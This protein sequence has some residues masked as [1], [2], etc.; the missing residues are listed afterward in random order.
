MNKEELYTTIKEVTT[1]IKCYKGFDSKLQCRGFQYEI[2][3]EYELPKGE[4]PMVCGNGFHACP[5]P[6]DLFL[7]YAPNNGN[8][9]CE[10]ELS[11]YI[12][13]NERNKLAASKIKIIRELPFNELAEAHRKYVEEHTDEEE[14]EYDTSNF[15][16]VSNTRT[17]SIASNMGIRSIACNSG[18]KSSVSNTGIFSIACNTGFQSSVTN[19]GFR[20]NSSNTGDFSCATNTGERSIA[21]NTG[22]FSSASNMGIRSIASN[23][24]NRSIASNMGDESIASNTGDYSCAE[25]SGKASFAAVF[26]IN[27]RVRGAI[28][29]GLFLTERGEWDGEKYPIKNVLAVIVDGEKVKANTWYKLVDGKLTEC[30]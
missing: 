24:G 5:N 23:T 27:C 20:S 3:K 29:C 26:G 4:M 14:K 11:G 1:P 9:F 21:S 22:D 13:D 12:D 2:G 16:T 7:F 8:R 28:G 17:Q 18:W 25:V 10:V 30:E 6:A 19:I 15:S